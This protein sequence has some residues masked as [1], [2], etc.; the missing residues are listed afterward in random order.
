LNC[1]DYCVV[2]LKG[3]SMPRLEPEITF[4]ISATP[5][6]D[7]TLDDMF[8]CVEWLAPSFE[9]VQSHKADWKPAATE[10]VADGGLHARQ[11]VGRRIPVRSMANSGTELNGMLAG[12]QVRLYRGQELVDQGPGAIVLD[13]PLQ[14]LVHFARELRACPGAPDLKAGDIVTTGTWTNAWALEAG[15]VW[16]ADFDA[17]LTTLEMVLR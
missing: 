8:R 1:D 4:G 3:T 2:D 13:G 9:L 7:A 5:P 14:S 15:Q 17:P 12:A 16:R 10:A 6:P 11:V